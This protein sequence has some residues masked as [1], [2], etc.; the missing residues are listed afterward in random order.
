MYTTPEFASLG[1][2]TI[3]VVAASIQMPLSTYYECQRTKQRLREM[4]ASQEPLSKVKPEEVS[5]GDFGPVKKHTYTN[6]YIYI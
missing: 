5:R 6:I 4:T 2:R 3:C 1:K